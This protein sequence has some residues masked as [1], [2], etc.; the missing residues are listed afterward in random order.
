MKY[1]ITLFRKI[2]EISG[3]SLMVLITENYEEY[4]E[5]WRFLTLMLE[6]NNTFIKSEEYKNNEVTR[7]YLTYDFNKQENK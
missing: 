3:D 4:I 6:H 7:L 2:G 1:T 5:A